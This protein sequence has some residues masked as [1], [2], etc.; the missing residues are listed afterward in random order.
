[1]RQQIS[2]NFLEMILLKRKSRSHVDSG[3]EIFDLP[4]LEL[5][6]DLTMERS[7]SQVDRFNSLDQKVSF[8]L[9]AATGFMGVA[10]VLHPF[11]LSHSHTLCTALTPHFLL[12][13][14]TLLRRALP[15]LP[16]LFSY[17]V[18]LLI[19]YRAYKT[20]QMKEVPQPQALKDYLRDPDHYTKA[21]IL[22]NMIEAY[23]QN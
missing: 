20:V 9:T 11:L 14:P 23:E 7:R 5:I 17:S 16:L 21:R 4:S 13:L 2:Q 18:V 15:L 1:M 22:A 10:F 8:S 19:W 6:F 3:K 12:L